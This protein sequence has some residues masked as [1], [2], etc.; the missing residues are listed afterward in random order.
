MSFKG[1]CVGI[2]AR[3]VGI[4]GQVKIHPYTSSPQSLISY[5]EFFLSDSS[6]IILINPKVNEKGDIISFLE[7]VTDRNA[8]ELLRL[9]RVF[10]KKESL[11]KLTEDE[12]Y[13]DDLSGLRVFNSQN[14]NIGRVLAGLD[15]GAGAFLDIKLSETDKMATLPFNKVSVT[16]VD[17]ENK[18]IY[19][20]EELLLQ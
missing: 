13:L 3:P 14:E 16:K 12:Y 19:I 10:I 5:K 18:S 11:P 6:K 15:Y 2:I 4:K 1:V 8:A 7:G 9:R 17:L 20:N